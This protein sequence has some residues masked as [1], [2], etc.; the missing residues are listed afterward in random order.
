MLVSVII[1][2]YNAE[3]YLR[4]CLDSVI[5]QT[6]KDIEIVIVDDGSTDSSS[7]IIDE[8]TVKYKNIV[9]I[10]TENRGIIEARKAGYD[11]CHGQYIC[12]VD[13]DD[14]IEPNMLQKLYETAKKGGGDYV[15]CDYDFYPKKVSTKEKWF[16]E[17]KGEVNWWFIERNTHPWNKMVSRE[18][19]E[20]FGMSE[21]LKEYGDSVYVGLLLHAKHIQSIPDVLYHYRVGHLSVSGGSFKN[22]VA[23]YKKVAQITKKQ[24]AFLKGTEYEKDL[25]EYFDYRYIYS[26][27]QL[28]VVSAYNSDKRVYDEAK[29]ELIRMN[30][31]TNKLVKTILDY[32][33]GKKKSLILRKIIPTNYLLASAI[34]KAAFR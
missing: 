32:N 13:N 6:L 3:K 5:N 8:Y 26:L 24:K 19:C 23:Y 28:M 17:Y 15:F 9:S 1:P 34:S 18:L 14:F 2:V 33:H 25:S 4:E 29:Q 27:L 20:E 31:S 21:R 7:K 12:W 11:L 16:K 22:K 30:Y 10:H